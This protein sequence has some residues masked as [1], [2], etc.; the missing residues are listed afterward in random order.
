MASDES[1]D[2]H[3][4]PADAAVEAQASGLVTGMIERHGRLD[5]LVNNAGY[6]LPGPIHDGGPSS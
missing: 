3:L 2:L 4:M 5:V 6:S 1:L